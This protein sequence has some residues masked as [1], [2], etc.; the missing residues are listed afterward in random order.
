MKI[1]L[2]DTFRI[3]ELIVHC[4]VLCWPFS[5]NII[6]YV[7]LLTNNQIFGPVLKI[8]R[9]PCFWD[10]LAIV[11]G[12]APESRQN[13][14]WTVQKPDIRSRLKNNSRAMFL[15]SSG[16][17]FGSGTRNGWKRLS[18]G[19]K[20]QIFGL[21][22]KI[23]RAPCFWADLTIVLGQKPE[24]LQTAFWM[25]ERATIFLSRSGNGFM[26]G[27]RIWHAPNGDWV[28]VR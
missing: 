4:R 13:D 3:L 19:F 7:S 5:V 11:W 15:S 12:Q 10:V 20:N 6:A 23:G 8:A 27:A 26:L 14:F 2:Y 22:P 24:M 17:S 25:T 9:E 21:D 18:G 16:N 28:I 1:E